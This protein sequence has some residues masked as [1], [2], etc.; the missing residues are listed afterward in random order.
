M[1]CMRL[2]LLVLLLLLCACALP[3]N[4]TSFVI[5]TTI[6]TIV[7]CYVLWILCVIPLQTAIQINYAGS[8]TWNDFFFLSSLSF[9]RCRVQT[10]YMYEFTLQLFM[11]QKRKRNGNCI[12][13]LCSFFF[14]SQEENEKTPHITSNKWNSFFSD[15]LS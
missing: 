8:Y 7:T 1:Y 11:M 13:W 14:H 9:V 3:F 5:E 4:S 2:L 10:E 6:N 12:R 15:H